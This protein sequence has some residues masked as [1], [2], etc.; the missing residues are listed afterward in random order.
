MAGNPQKI[1]IVGAGV[2]GLY[3]AWQLSL[4]GHK[5]SVYEKSSKERSWKKSCSTLVSE[6]IRNFIPMDDSFIENK[7]S[8][9]LI[10]FPKKT[11]RL[12]FRPVHLVLS[13][14]AVLAR[15]LE[16]AQKEG[17][18]VFFEKDIKK[19]P[20]GF[21]KIIGCDGAL[22]KIRESLALSIPRFR[23]GVQFFQ[24][25]KDGSGLV[26]TWPTKNG[27]CWRIPREKKRSGGC[28][29]IRKPL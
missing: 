18:E 4:K 12:D 2:I 6:R 5:V 7:I 17:A 28:S 23:L 14:P 13:R 21:D 25:E 24:K 3:L 22:S 27:F 29:K 10:N 20:E 26:E 11:V 15:L 8:G 1:L 9:C 19:I 16:L